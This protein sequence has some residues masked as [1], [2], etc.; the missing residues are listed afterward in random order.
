VKLRDF[1]NP[2]KKRKTSYTYKESNHDFRFVQR[3]TNSLHRLRY[4]GSRCSI[5]WYTFMNVSTGYS[6]SIF[7]VSRH[8]GKQFHLQLCIIHTV[9]ILTINIPTKN[10]FN[11]VR[12]ITIIETTCFGSGIPFSVSFTTKE[13]KSNTRK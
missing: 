5:V 1:L 10:A 3:I 4:L 6:A 12:F 2:V 13:Y 9:H 7:R 8:W 11:K